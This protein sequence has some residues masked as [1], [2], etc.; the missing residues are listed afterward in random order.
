MNE[1]IA[2][3]V[4]GHVIAMGLLISMVQIVFYVF[5]ADL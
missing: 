5:L 4:V 3:E 2:L 1:F